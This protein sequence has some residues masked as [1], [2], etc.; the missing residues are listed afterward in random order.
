M[1]EKRGTLTTVT[2]VKTPK[3]FQRKRQ[4]PQWLKGNKSLRILQ[5]QRHAERKGKGVYQ[6]RLRITKLFKEL[7]ILNMRSQLT[8]L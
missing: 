2:E 1:V 7:G 6:G 3:T 4:G 5:G 8:L